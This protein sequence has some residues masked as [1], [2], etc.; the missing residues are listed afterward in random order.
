MGAII[1]YM[2]QRG[3]PPVLMRKIK[4][5]YRRYFKSK[6]ALDEKTILAELPAKLKT[7]SSMFLVSKITHQ[8][9]LF[10]ELIFIFLYRFYL[11]A[12]GQDGIFHVLSTRPLTLSPPPPRPPL[13]YSR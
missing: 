13:T 6:S 2:N 11:A 7:E 5:F 12:A 1:S 4:R 10:D 8:M 9:F 3:F